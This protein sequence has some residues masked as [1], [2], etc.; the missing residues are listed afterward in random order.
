MI[1]VKLLKWE[2]DEVTTVFGRYLVSSTHGAYLME[3]EGTSYENAIKL[4]EE[5]DIDLLKLACQNDYDQK[6]LK[7]HD[8]MYLV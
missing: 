8:E 1:E 7:L 3:N 2:N 5:H 4:S 6:A